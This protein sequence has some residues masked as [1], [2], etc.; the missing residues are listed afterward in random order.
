MSMVDDDT[1]PVKAIRSIANPE[2]WCFS[3]IAKI[4]S[5]CDTL[6]SQLAAR[7]WVSVEDRLPHQLTR[8]LVGSL[9]H[10]EV[11]ECELVGQLWY[12]PNTNTTFGH[13]T[14]WQPLHP[15]PKEDSDV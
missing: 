2:T 12:Y 3:D 1:D 7:E 15:P 13:V 6:E 10:D 14:H 9:D 11:A 4:Q 5:L 8:V